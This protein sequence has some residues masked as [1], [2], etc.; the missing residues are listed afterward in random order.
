MA[1]M[2]DN[3]QWFEDH[4]PFPD[5]YK[6]PEVKGIAKYFERE[7]DLYDD[8]SVEEYEF[9]IDV[10]DGFDISAF[11]AAPEAGGAVSLGADEGGGR[12]GGGSGAGGWQAC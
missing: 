5:A 2:M 3:A 6:K 11:D 4:M 12:A 9:A 8:G 7:V 1:V 10:D